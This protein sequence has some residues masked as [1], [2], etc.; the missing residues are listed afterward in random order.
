MPDPCVRK[1]ITARTSYCL[2]APN[3]DPFTRLITL[4]YNGLLLL[5]LKDSYS[6][7]MINQRRIPSDEIRRRTQS[8]P[9]ATSIV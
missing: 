1:V 6:H 3:K 7:A 4:I 9:D 5:Y 2:Q 8:I